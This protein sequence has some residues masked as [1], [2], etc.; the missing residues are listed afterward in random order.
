MARKVT[1]TKQKETK[2]SIDMKEE[3]IRY[4]IDSV[5]DFAKFYIKSRT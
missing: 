1:Q 4:Y 3:I 2:K 5:I